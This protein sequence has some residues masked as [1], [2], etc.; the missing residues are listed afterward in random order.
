MT[1]HSINQHTLEICLVATKLYSVSTYSNTHSHNNIW[2]NLDWLHHLPSVLNLLHN[3]FS[4]TSVTDMFSYYLDVLYLLYL[5]SLTHYFYI[6]HWSLSAAASLTACCDVPNELTHPSHYFTGIYFPVCPHAV[7]C[8][9]QINPSVEDLSASPQCVIVPFRNNF[10]LNCFG[11]GTLSGC[12]ILQASFWFISQ[13]EY[14]T[15]S[16]IKWLIRP[17][18]LSPVHHTVGER[19]LDLLGHLWR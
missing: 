16:W 12:Q 15:C 7:T 11:N 3:L 6:N 10:T 13:R 2:I 4:F 19:R 14:I 18:D 1:L 8:K 5:A 9:N 17:S